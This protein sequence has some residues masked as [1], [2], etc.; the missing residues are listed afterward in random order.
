[1]S[2][3]KKPNNQSDF[4]QYDANYWFAKLNCSAN[5]LS[6]KQAAVIFSTANNFIKTDSGFVRDI[7]QLLSQFK[8]PLMLL[9]IGAVVLSAFLGD[10]TDVYI[11]LFI[12]LST[13][14]LI[15]L[16]L[17]YSPIA[18][19]IGLSPLPLLNLSAMLLIVTA[20]IFTADVLKVW[21]FK[22]YRS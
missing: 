8:S 13:G 4:W 18:A 14:L 21:F 2:S 17:P 15:T 10:T 22:K 9:L 12:V 19:S 1:M 7:K 11:I 3:S 5:G 6:Q 16:A 20:Y